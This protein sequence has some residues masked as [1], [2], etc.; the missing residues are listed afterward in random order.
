MNPSRQ[1]SRPHDDAVPTPRDA[2]IL[3]IDESTLRIGQQLLRLLGNEHAADNGD[4]A[5][6]GAL[7]WPLLVVS[8]T[9]GALRLIQHVQPRGLFVCVGADQLEMAATLIQTIRRRRNGLPQV[10][11]A[12]EHDERIELAVRRAGAAYYFPLAGRFDRELVDSALGAIGIGPAPPV[13]R[14]ERSRAAPGPEPHARGR[15][16]TVLGL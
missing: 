6:N 14:P 10:A 16:P 2:L 13:H 9:G 3:A 1:A 15:P 4:T 11:L 7:D 8:G 5:G 12:G